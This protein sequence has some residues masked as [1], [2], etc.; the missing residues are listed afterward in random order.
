MNPTLV[1]ASEN[2]DE[3]SFTMNQTNVSVANALRRTILNDIPT[4]T[5]YTDTYQDNQCTVEVNTTRLHNELIKHRLSC[6]PIHMTELDILPGKYILEVDVTNDT[7]VMMFVTTEH[8]RIRNKENGNLLTKDE[9]RKIFPM[10]AKT[11]AYIDFARL[12]GKIAD[13]IP[14]E[15]LKLT[16][17][18]SVHSAKDNS[19]F[20][21][22]SKCAYGN[23]PDLSKTAEVWQEQEDKLS[24]E[25][26]SADDIAF[27][28]RNFY[29]LDSQRYFVPDSF[30]FIIQTVGVYENKEIVKKACLI[31]IDKFVDLITAIESD[32]IPILNSES[33]MDFCYD[34]ILENEDYTIGKVMEYLVYDKYYVN[35]K[36]VSYCGFKKFHPHNADSTLRIAY[37]QTADKQTVK[38]HLFSVCTDA[39]DI[40]NKVARQF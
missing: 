6:I 11:N 23:T 21:V 35:E 34:I 16:C 4:L 26:T 38:S 8:F 36:I 24:S 28:K 10:C 22:V 40:F 33:T 17:E 1:S 18:F 31:L 32:T 30:D 27:Q 25:E 3:Y 14:G 5:F 29:I 13:S 20:N 39:K 12:R 2:G 15:Q 37:T 9:T 19:M 7:E